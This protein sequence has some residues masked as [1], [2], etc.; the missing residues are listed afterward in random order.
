MNTVQVRLAC[1]CIPKRKMPTTNMERM[2]Y[3]L[4]HGY[5]NV[6]HYFGQEWH[7][8][9][10]RP[11]CRFSRWCA[12]DENLAYRHQQRHKTAHPDHFVT[13]AYDRVTPDGKG[14]TFRDMKNV[15]RTLL[16]PQYEPA[17]LDLSTQ[18]PP[19]F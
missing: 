8:R 1:G 15:P 11:G 6:D 12:Q 4:Y 17:T 10:T 13:V 16:H 3:C 7:A 14:S 19:P 9:C 5:Q 2:W 18:E